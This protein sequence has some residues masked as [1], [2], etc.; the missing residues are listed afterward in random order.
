MKKVTVTV[1]EE[2]ALWLQGRAARANRSV[3][4]WLAAMID[5]A[6]RE[7]CEYK[8]AME[9]SLARK[10]RKMGWVDARRPTRDELHDRTG[11]R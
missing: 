6:R 4:S 9:R 5:G 7:E 1:P 2:T 8:L 3:S 11:L 10:P